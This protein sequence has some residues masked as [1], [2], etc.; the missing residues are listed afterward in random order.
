MQCRICGDDSEHRTYQ[1]KEM[2]LGKHDEHTYFQCNHCQCLQIANVPEDIASYYPDNYYSYADPAQQSGLKSLLMRQRDQYAVTGKSLLGRLLQFASP[3]DK[4]A[5]LRPLDL[6][7][8][9]KILDIGCGAGHLLHSLKELRFENLLGLDPFNQED[10]RY[11]NG[12]IIEKR[13]IFSETKTWDVIMF[14][15]SFEHLSDQHGTLQKAWE[16]LTPGGTVLIRVPT[17]SSYAWQHYGVNWVQLDAPRHLFLHSVESIKQL[18]E[19]HGFTLE[20]TLYDSFAFQFWGSEQYEQGIDLRS[21]RSYAENQH[22]AI[23]SKQEIKAFAKRS[24]EL[25]AV[26]Q[27][28]QAAFYLRKAA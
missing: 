5:M 15:H 2:M 10:I 11:E 24:K 9:S 27:G 25:N 14:H 22:T 1:V 13:D 8:D 19:Q 28:D 26:N 4:L 17:V 20:K 6:Q 18:A 3:N 21:P 16:Q 7:K 23:F 12:L